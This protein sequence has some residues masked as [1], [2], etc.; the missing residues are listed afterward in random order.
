MT[1]KVFVTLSIQ[2]IDKENGGIIF[3][4]NEEIVGTRTQEGV[5]VTGSSAFTH[6]VPWDVINEKHLIPKQNK[7]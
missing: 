5:V 7:K 1:N 2:W 3:P 6:T 4:A